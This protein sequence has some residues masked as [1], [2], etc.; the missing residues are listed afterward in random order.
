MWRLNI[1]EIIQIAYQPKLSIHMA[2]ILCLF[3]N[4][5]SKNYGLCFLNY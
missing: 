2:L 3:L 1:Q 5:A 4:T